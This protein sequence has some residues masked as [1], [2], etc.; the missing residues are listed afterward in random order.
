MKQLFPQLAVWI[1]KRKLSLIH[2]P[3]NT[4]AKNKSYPFLLWMYF[5]DHFSYAPQP[6]LTL[7]WPLSYSQSPACLLAYFNFLSN[8]SFTQ[9][10]RG[11][12]QNF[13]LIVSLP[14]KSFSGL[15]LPAGR[16]WNPDLN[17]ICACSPFQGAPSTFPPDSPAMSKCLFWKAPKL[18]F[19][20]LCAI[21]F[22]TRNALFSSCLPDKP[23]YSA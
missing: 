2:F 12:C 5:S 18:L 10:P 4:T 11:F 16:S 21:N 7:L 9:W 13:L 15:V 3:L 14:L 17:T 23:Q 1:P 6:N 20:P 22:S 19:S 8:M